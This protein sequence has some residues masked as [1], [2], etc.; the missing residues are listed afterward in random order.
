MSAHRACRRPS[1]SIEGSAETERR[2]RQARRGAIPQAPHLYRVGSRR[3]ELGGARRALIWSNVE[4]FKTV[5]AAMLVKV[6]AFALTSSPGP[7]V[8]PQCSKTLN[9]ACGS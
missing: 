6:R 9:S 7:N 2:F 4:E 8:P 3:V 5:V 1:P